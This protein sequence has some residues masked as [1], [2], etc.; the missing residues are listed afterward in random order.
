MKLKHHA[1]NQTSLTTPAGATL[2]FSYE[3][4]VAAF[5][6]G[7]GFFRTT[8]TFS[9]TTSRH[10]NQWLRAEGAFGR[11]TFTPPEEF[12]AIVRHIFSAAGE[13]VTAAEVFNTEAGK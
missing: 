6:P 12:A 3:T 7:R 4:P 11:E 2:F 10:V 9:R 13:I 1:A 5:V 8:E